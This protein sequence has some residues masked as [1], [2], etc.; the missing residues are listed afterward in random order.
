VIS[1]VRPKRE[2]R[3]RWRQNAEP[4][5]RALSAMAAVNINSYNLCFGWKYYISILFDSQMKSILGK[6]SQFFI[7]HL[8]HRARWLKN[9]KTTS[10]SWSSLVGGQDLREACDLRV[11]SPNPETAKIC[12]KLLFLPSFRVYGY[13]V[14]EEQLF[15]KSSIT[16]PRIVVNHLPKSIRFQNCQKVWNED[17][18]IVIIVY[19]AI[20]S[21]HYFV[22]VTLLLRIRPQL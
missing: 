11:M 4:R 17:I 20:Y 7:C 3:Q 22:F 6:S 2:S 8:L 5:L 10:S 16:K 14:P 21:T 12:E 18:E 1:H 13:D 19:T 15:T 9:K